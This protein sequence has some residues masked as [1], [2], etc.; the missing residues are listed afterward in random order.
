MKRDELFWLRTLIY[1][2]FFLLIFEG[3]LR[4][5]IVPSLSGPLLVARD[6]VLMAIYTMV[7]FRGMFPWN[8][9]YLSA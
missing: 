5:W 3:A 9:V 7:I 2:Y 8:A 1:V 6:P 4:K